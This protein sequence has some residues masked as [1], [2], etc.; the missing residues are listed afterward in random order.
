MK[1]EISVFYYSLV[2]NKIGQNEKKVA[3]KTLMPF[4]LRWI[5]AR[6][7]KKACNLWFV[8]CSFNCSRDFASRLH[9]LWY[10]VAQFSKQTDTYTSWRIYCFIWLC[11][12]CQIEGFKS[13]SFSF[14]SVLITVCW[15]YFWPICEFKMQYNFIGLTFRDRNG[16]SSLCFKKFAWC[17]LHLN[18]ILENRI[19]KSC[20]ML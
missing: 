11:N 7:K 18:Q 19:W 13:L 4:S 3:V 9:Y 5:M 17:R 14:L 6:D 20:F 8:S 2:C 15:Y 10:G 1:V 12:S 16:D